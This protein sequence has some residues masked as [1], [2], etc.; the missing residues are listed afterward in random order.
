MIRRWIASG[1]SSTG[2][3]TDVYGKRG[4]TR[5]TRPPICEPNSK[6]MHHEHNNN[7]SHTSCTACLKP[8]KW[9]LLQRNCWIFLFI[10][11]LLRSDTV[12]DRTWLCVIRWDHNVM[13]SWK[14]R[15]TR[16]KYESCHT[17]YFYSL[18]CFTL[19]LDQSSGQTTDFVK[20][21]FHNT[22]HDPD[23]QIMKLGGNQSHPYLTPFA[24]KFDW[25]GR[26]RVSFIRLTCSTSRHL[27]LP[28]PR[29][30]WESRWLCGTA[31]R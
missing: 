10:Y 1:W 21:I 31:P 9:H 18:S 27:L 14:G 7:I 13:K 8:G 4:R 30:H 11:F 24:E 20:N 12:V 6:I 2:A 29:M 26:R 23:T 19:P 16:E 5:R 3:T 25:T 22:K 17:L 28:S 15:L